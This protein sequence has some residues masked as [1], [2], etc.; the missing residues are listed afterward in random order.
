MHVY[1]SKSE[2]CNLSRMVK[3]FVSNKKQVALSIRLVKGI[4]RLW[5]GRYILVQL[6]R[7]SC[8]FAKDVCVYDSV[9]ILGK[10]LSAATVFLWTA[11]EEAAF[12]LGCLRYC[13]LIGQWASL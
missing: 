1:D 4:I 13:G 3:S 9:D 11:N 7:K 5:L 6:I 8:K 10:S 12:C 2:K